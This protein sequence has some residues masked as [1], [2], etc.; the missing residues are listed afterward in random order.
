LDSKVEKMRLINCLRGKSA[1]NK[2]VSYAQD[3]AFKA[4]RRHI[5]AACQSI[6]HNQSRH[7][8]RRQAWP[9][10][11]LLIILFGLIMI[12]AASFATADLAF[13]NN[14]LTTTTT[15]FHSPLN[16]TTLKA[17]F[18]RNNTND[19]NENL[20]RDFENAT[21]TTTITTR[22]LFVVNS[23]IAGVNNDTSTTATSTTNPRT[24]TS[25]DD[26]D[27]SPT[28][29]PND[30]L[31][32]VTLTSDEV[33]SEDS[34]STELSKDSPLEE[35]E[36]ETTTSTVAA[37]E[38]NTSDS[39]ESAD[40]TEST[41][42]VGD[43]RVGDENA[44]DARHEIDNNNEDGDGDADDDDDERQLARST[45][46]SVASSTIDHLTNKLKEFKQ[47]DDDNNEPTDD[48][49]EDST[50][51]DNASTVADD[52]SA[53][54]VS[55][56][57][58]TDDNNEQVDKNS[59]AKSASS[60]SGG[61]SKRHSIASPA[62][63]LSLSSSSST[64][65]DKSKAEAIIDKNNNSIDAN[66][67]SI[68]RDE[69]RAAFEAYS[70]WIGMSN[71]MI[72]LFSIKL[73]PLIIGQAYEIDPQT[74]TGMLNVFNAV[75]G[76]KPWSLMLLDSWAKL[77]PGV[78]QGT[79]SEFGDYDE[80]LA[81]SSE[82]SDE[83]PTIIR[84]QYCLADVVFPK[85]PRAFVASNA[86]TNNNKV[87]EREPIQLRQRLL[88]FS[89]VSPYNGT[90]FQHT[91]NFFHMLYVDPIRV[92]I[93]LTTQV[94]AESFERVFNNLLAPMRVSIAFNGR[95]VSIDTLRAKQMSPFQ[96]VSLLVL[97][98]ALLAVA[99]ST[100]IDILL[101]RAGSHVAR[102]YGTSKFDRLLAN[103]SVHS[104]LLTSYS[105]VRNTRKLFAPSSQSLCP[106]PNKTAVNDAQSMNRPRQHQPQWSE[107]VQVALS[108]TCDKQ[109][110][111]VHR[112]SVSSLLTSSSQQSSNLNATTASSIVE[113]TTD[114]L[115][116]QSIG[117]QKLK[118]C[119]IDQVTEK[120]QHQQQQQTCCV[121]ESRAV[122]MSC[123]H[124]LRVITMTWM[125][126]NHTYLFGGFFVL[127]AYR[128]LI[129]V[130]E[131]P[132]SLTF[133]LVLNGWL[134][135]ETYFFLSA[136]II[137]YT[138]L[139]LFQRQQSSSTAQQESKRARFNYGA[140]LVHRITRLLPAYL[141]VICLNFLWPL[142]SSGPVWLVKGHEF[143][144]RPCEQYMWANLL[145][146]NNWFWPEN[147]VQGIALFESKLTFTSKRGA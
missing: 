47:Q 37:S 21:T 61:L 127:W 41:P 75:R 52:S 102:K 104:D 30:I 33:I 138:L 72:E 120:H 124:G 22:P 3:E 92:G 126:I 83:V 111:A 10:T 131:W 99:C 87:Q 79:Q 60:S 1:P 34:T 38:T 114:S 123:L 36:K 11:C 95:C 20:N 23:I 5:N 43:E 29:T 94:K 69:L 89:K 106:T 78:L 85:P 147:M 49:A 136:L 67:T 117:E 28:V 44:E 109:Q 76:L 84:G 71:D 32:N 80:C 143:I 144:E 35:E 9:T 116:E 86:R 73:L 141:G 68:E 91:A 101:T 8:R 57:R 14:N 125:I 51:D 140:Y 88:D 19:L 31:T 42:P 135:V 63:S 64:N 113:S 122:N 48:S 12:V 24:T 103:I 98:V 118:L 145:F 132:K 93:C 139:P 105:I 146:I 27:L 96:A 119:S 90:I 137:V 112:S 25:I 82:P 81:I 54:Q 55:S 121:K 46:N 130:A 18:N 7:R 58:P 65:A 134:T 40:A 66:K 17:K 128:R 59:I 97:K 13:E 53:S 26:E 110:I 6:S 108:N 15:T 39:S 2:R 133:Q 74:M 45:F 16:F 56:E 77:A 50:S 142:I 100:L 129:E 107:N 70:R 115:K 62:L 4:K